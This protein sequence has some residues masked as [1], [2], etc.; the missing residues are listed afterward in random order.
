MQMGAYE[1]KTKLSELL[2][3]VEAGEH[4]SITRYGRV[5]AVLSPPTGAADRTADEAVNGILELRK[6]RRLGGD[7]TIRDLIDAGRR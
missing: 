2:D 1:A 6:G 7:L 5:V 4:I 3:R